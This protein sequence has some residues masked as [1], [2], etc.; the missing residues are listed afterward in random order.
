MKETLRKEERVGQEAKRKYDSTLSNLDNVQRHY[1]ILE[2]ES[3][4]LKLWNTILNGEEKDIKSKMEEIEI[5]RIATE[6]QGEESKVWIV[7]LEAQNISLEVPL[8]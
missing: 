4:A 3:D 8:K 2:E 6:N 5:Q 7:E 1:H